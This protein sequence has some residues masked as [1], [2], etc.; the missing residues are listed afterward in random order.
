MINISGTYQLAGRSEA[1]PASAMLYETG[2][3]VIQKSGSGTRLI[4]VWPDGYKY[5][6]VI[7]GLPVDIEFSD[8]A[9]FIPHDNSFRWPAMDRNHRL[10]EWL[11][12]H[13]LTVLSSVIIVPLFMWSMVNY[14]LPGASHAAVAFLPDS[15]AESMGEQTLYILD[16]TYFDPTELSDQQ[17]QQVKQQWQIIVTK[18]DLPEDR[19]KLHFRKFDMGANAM[20]LPDGSI[21]V[22]DDIVTL[23]E[24]DP[25]ALI[26]V[27]LHEIG[28]VEHK[29]SLKMIAQ[30]TATTMLFA[31]MF[32]DIEG[33]G[34]LILGAG[35]G[36]LQSAFSR[37]MEREAD[38]FS[39]Q[40]LPKFNISPAAFADA[41]TLLVDSHS[42][43]D[44]AS[45]QTAGNTTDVS[46]EN[47][48]ITNSLN[49]W[50]QYLSSHPETQERI[51]TA[52]KKGEDDNDL[53][54]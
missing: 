27:L 4:E 41:M 45:D 20:A 35:T 40:N 51:N 42:S 44:E 6:I 18:L 23:M 54:Y 9:L 53:L 43:A 50:L 17:Q 7:P 15:I 25:N 36:L 33:A 8:G 14:V 31:M 39:Y 29:H 22:T 49:H 37:D 11:E 30:T 13:W 19:F 38:E 47:S 48:E 21:I 26:A 52:R 3:L 12:S 1:H 2:Q 5:G 10:A 32:G 34:E 24:K 28:H 46:A 16:K